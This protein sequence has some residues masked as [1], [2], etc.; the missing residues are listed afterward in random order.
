MKRA[1]AGVELADD[2]EQEELVE[3]SDRLGERGAVVGR[4]LDAPERHLQLAE[5]GALLGEERL[6]VLA[7]QADGHPNDLRRRRAPSA[8][9][10]SPRV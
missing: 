2:D 10:A 5:R 9:W 4:G 1:L 6:L 7:Q 8:R 3:L